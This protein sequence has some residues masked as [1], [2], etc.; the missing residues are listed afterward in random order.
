MFAGDEVSPNEI[1]KVLGEAIGKPGLKWITVSDE[2]LLDGMRHA[3][4][5]PSLAKCFVEANASTSRLGGVLYEDFF[6][7]KPTLGKVKIG[8]FTKEFA[9]AY[10]KTQN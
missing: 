8:A 9:E 10:H 6:R 5:S 7:N 3:G 4:M 2:Q 1:A